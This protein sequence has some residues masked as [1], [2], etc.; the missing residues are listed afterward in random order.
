MKRLQSLATI[1]LLSALPNSS[2]S[3]GSGRGNQAGAALYNLKDDLPETKS[4]AQ[5]NPEIVAS[6]MTKLT[7]ITGQLPPSAQPRKSKKSKTK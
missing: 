3:A 1:I 2:F 7:Q 5:S 4:V 6:M